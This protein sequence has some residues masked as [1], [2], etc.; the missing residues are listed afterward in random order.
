MRETMR[1][2]V[3]LFLRGPLRGLYEGSKSPGWKIWP[4]A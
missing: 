2:Y 4:E 1:D 3:H